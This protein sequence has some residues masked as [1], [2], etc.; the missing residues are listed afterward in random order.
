MSHSLSLVA[1]RG[2]LRRSALILIASVAPF[3]L[4]AGMA[5]AADAAPAPQMPQMSPA[6]R[7]GKSWFRPSAATKR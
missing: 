3:A 6:L 7:P 2:R 4:D 1:R 5:H